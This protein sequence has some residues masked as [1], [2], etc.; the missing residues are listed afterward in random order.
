MWQNLLPCERYD[1]TCPIFSLPRLLS[2][3]CSPVLSHHSNEM[4]DSNNIKCGIYI[5]IW[6]QIC[7]MPCHRQ[8]SKGRRLQED[9]LTIC[10]ICITMALIVKGA[11]IK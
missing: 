4:V 11:G 9:T 5:K 7:L 1:A 8:F 10:P 6:F 2:R 3:L